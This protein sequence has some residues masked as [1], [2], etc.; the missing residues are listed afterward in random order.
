MSLHGNAINPYKPFSGLPRFV[1]DLLAAPP[2]HG[3]GVHRY[4]FRLARVL[5]H[6]RDEGEIVAILRAVSHECG[7][8]VPDRE[9]QNA[10]RNSKSVAWSPR[11]NYNSPHQLLVWPKINDEQREAIIS[12]GPG[13]VD[14]WELSPRRLD[15]K[16]CHTEEIID[17]LFPQNSLLCCGRTKAKFHTRPRDDWRG[18]LGTLQFIV[19]SPMSK[20]I[21]RAQAGHDSA[22]CLDNTGPRRFLVVEFDDGSTDDHAAIL[23]HLA[24]RAPLALAVHSGGKS[25]HGWFY[26]AQQC[27]PSLR[28]FM[29][30]AVTLGADPMTWTPCQFVRMPDGQRDNGNRQPILFFNPEVV[31]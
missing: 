14:L 18:Q 2:R 17:A 5:H 7:R 26:C 19:P 21:G 1:C 9:I 4:L 15:S 28:V 3:D 16:E 30:Y 11:A 27:D 23:L 24:A 25:L 31:R 10:V 20:S 29:R 12:N 13:A 22:H 8:E 6:Y